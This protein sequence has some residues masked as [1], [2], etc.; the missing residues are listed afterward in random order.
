MIVIL[1]LN[2]Y[3]YDATRTNLYYSITRLIRSHV[4]YSFII[5]RHGAR[6]A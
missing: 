4:R 6:G 1:F 5:W 2:I 3:I